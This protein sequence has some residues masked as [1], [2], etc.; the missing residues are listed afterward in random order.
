[1]RRHCARSTWAC[2][3]LL[4]LWACAARPARAQSTIAAD[5]AENLAVGRSATDFFSRLR[6]QSVYL[7]LP[8]DAQLLST[9]LTGTYS[10][11]PDV[12]LRLRLPL[13]YAV[14]GSGLSSQFGVGDLSTRALWRPWHTERAAAVVG[15]ELFFP[16]ASDPLLGTE[17]YSIVPTAA[18]LYQVVDNIFIV[19]I[20]QQ[21]ISYAGNDDRADLNILRI[22]P[23]ILA[24]WPRGW[25]TA[26]DP[27]FLWDLEDDRPT[28]DTMTLGL[29]V[30][31]R[32]TRR[33]SL[34]GKPA[35]QVY[36]SEDF[37]WAAELALTFSF[38]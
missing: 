26:L 12:A 8:G 34:A 4:A 14:P 7:N 19:P 33:L 5:I 18:F 29:E 27:G 36:G 37:V 13:N 15:V 1:V 9:R 3:A 6:A 2:L 38:Q 17:K 31:K 35:I 25:W 11:H 22:R 20:Y 24:Q 16:T 28:D 30:G 23:I 32:L 21:L 10:P